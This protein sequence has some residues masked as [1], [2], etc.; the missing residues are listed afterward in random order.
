MNSTLQTSTQKLREARAFPR[1][2]Q[3]GSIEAGPRTRSSDFDSIDLKILRGQLV[4]L[5]AS[6]H[7]LPK[8]SLLPCLEEHMW[9][10]ETETN[11]PAS[12]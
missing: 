4:R 5:P 12:G 8:V 9:S 3:P 11:Q 7:Q 2:T 10:V 1:V 6:P